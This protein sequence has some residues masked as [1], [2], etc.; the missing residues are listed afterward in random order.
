MMKADEL[1]LRFQRFLLSLSLL[2]SAFT[3]LFFGGLTGSDAVEAAIKLARYIKRRI[4]L[5]SLEGSFHRM[6]SGALFLSGGLSF[7]EGF[8]PMLPEVHHRRLSPDRYGYFCRPFE[9]G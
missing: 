8:L 6:T 1:F 2:P 4:P 3:G 7:K 9:R 5:I